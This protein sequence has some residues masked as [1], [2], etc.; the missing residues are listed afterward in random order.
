MFKKIGEWFN[1]NKE[2]I[3]SAVTGFWNGWCVGAGVWLFVVTI[4]SFIFMR[5]TKE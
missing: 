4:Y 3:K 1:R 2:V 5:K